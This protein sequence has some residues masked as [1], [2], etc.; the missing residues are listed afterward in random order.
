MPNF[1]HPATTLAAL[2]LL[3]LP[4]AALAWDEE[5]PLPENTS[6]Q[7]YPDWVND[8]DP[9]PFLL[10]LPALPEGA[11]LRSHNLQ[12]A[13]TPL[14]GVEP[15]SLW[16]VRLAQYFTIPG[17]D[18][19]AYVGLSLWENASACKLAWDEGMGRAGPPVPPV[20]DDPRLDAADPPFRRCR[21]A[22]LLLSLTDAPREWGP[23][24]LG[25]ALDRLLAADSD[26][27][28]CRR[29]V[30]GY[31]QYVAD[32]F[33]EAAEL[34]AYWKYHDLPEETTVTCLFQRGEQELQRSQQELGGTGWATFALAAIGAG[35]APG[36]YLVQM[37]EGEKV[38]AEKEFAVGRLPGTTGVSPVAPPTEPGVAITG[39]TS[40]TAGPEVYPT[41][42]GSLHFWLQYTQPGTVL[43]TVGF[44]AAAP[45]DW[46]VKIE[47]NGF[48]LFGLWD[49]NTD[50]VLKDP[51][52]WHALTSGAPLEKD[53]W[54]EVTLT[55][56]TRGMSVTVDG[57]ERRPPNV[58][59]PL[60]GQPA[61]YGDF[62][63][64][65]Q[66]AD[67]FNVHPACTGEVRGLTFEGPQKQ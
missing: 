6:G 10:P 62:P 57:Q 24:L 23:A 63:G 54:H 39:P 40:A 28:V 60:S 37:R 46:M 67:R 47:P 43:D 26:L 32:N 17:T 31:P 51:A 3:L 44:N 45:G 18:Q 29:V 13:L 2:V 61:W 59:L 30:G 12:I 15:R 50:S 9:R 52:G 11:R 19:S 56:G 34:S 4:L 42:D 7:P 1:S 20:P 25:A 64:D 35:F 27:V 38:L 33:P 49:K 22:R 55:Y 41:T 48:L 53:K 14:A 8:F 65:D 58:T 16:S 21:R 5:F 36:D 66:W